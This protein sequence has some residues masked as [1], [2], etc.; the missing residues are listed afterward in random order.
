MDELREKVRRMFCAKT[1]HCKAACVG[2]RV[3]KH[4][5]GRWVRS[6][7]EAE[8][9]ATMVHFQA[10]GLSPSRAAMERYVH[11]TL[12][13]RNEPFE[14][15]TKLT[16]RMARDAVDKLKADAAEVGM[17]TQQYAEIALAISDPDMVREAQEIMQAGECVLAPRGRFMKPKYHD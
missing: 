5:L 9:N 13:R 12:R 11:E 16:V 8:F 3:K 14:G 17:S 10:E 15:D 6:M 7:T 1:P 2:C 4:R